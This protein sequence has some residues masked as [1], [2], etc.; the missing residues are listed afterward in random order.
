MKVLKRVFLYP[1][2]IMA[3]SM[4]MSLPAFAQTM[5]AAKSEV[6]VFE[7]KDTNSK[8]L[9]KLKGG[10]EVLIEE[11]SGDNKWVSIL[12]EPEG[13]DGQQLAWIPMSDMADAMPPEFCQH[14]WSEMTVMEEPTCTAG[15]MQGHTCSICGALEAVDIPPLPHSFGDWTVTKQATCTAE[16]EMTRACT[17]CGLTETQPIERT[18]HSFSG[19]VVTKEPT[20]TAEGEQV[21]TCSICGQEEKQTLQM[22]PHKFTDWSVNKQATCT[23]E[24]ERV[25]KCS[26]CGLEEKQTVERLP[27]SFGDWTVTKQATCTA[28]GE[29]THK[30]KVCGYETKETVAKLPHDFEWKVIKEATDH[31]SGIRSSV[32]KKC[33][34]KQEEVSYDPEGTLRRGD[35]SEGVREIQQLL[36]DQNYL[37]DGGADGIFGAGTEKALMA[38]QSAQGLTPD[39]I[40]WPQTILR[41]RHNYGEWVIVKNPTRHSAGERT[42]ACKDCNYVQHEVIELDPYLESGRR[43]EDVRAVQQMLGALGFDAGNYDGIYGP[44]LDNAYKEFADKNNVEFEAGK[45]YPDNIDALVNAWLASIPETEWMGEGSL[46]TPTNLVLTV[47]PVLE[48]QQ[49]VEVPV[50]ETEAA[51]EAIEEET[52]AVS[53]GEEPAEDEEPETIITYNWSLTNMGSEPCIFT[54]LLLTFGDDPDFRADTLTMAIDGAELKANCGNSVSG[55]FKVSSK[56]GK[57]AANFSALAVSEENGRKWLSNTNTFAPEEEETE[58]AAEAVTEGEFEEV[59]ETSEETA[60]PAPAESAEAETQEE[61]A[62]A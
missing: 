4:A 45:L 57:G 10:Q 60:E 12:V 32:C 39:G 44:K 40:A 41:L 46:D 5:F 25:R 27:H 11:K 17:M 38:F 62:A 31:S 52:E 20:C 54:T 14:Q 19:W 36:A 13:G 43:A 35:V 59:E 15:G 18:A 1:L 33:G 8:V 58:E 21:S 22:V 24:G 28:E 6:K 47:T 61:S 50:I 2:I 7:E 55:S 3:L 53:E 34:Y 30:C 26:V 42:R 23:A 9:K 56:W 51:S 49:T 29:R 48:E 37:N 16:G